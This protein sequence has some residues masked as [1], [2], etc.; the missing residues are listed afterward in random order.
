MRH[1]RQLNSAQVSENVKG[2]LDEPQLSVGGFVRGLD[3]KPGEGLVAVILHLVPDIREHGSVCPSLHLVEDK[4]V[5]V[6][7]DHV[8]AVGEIH[9][10]LQLQLREAVRAQIEELRRD[11]G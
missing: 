7:V 10:F 3:V 6:M 4:A 11:N 1:C 9:Q 2:F 5:L 8:C